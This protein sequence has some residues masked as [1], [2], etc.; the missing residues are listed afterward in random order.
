MKKTF[1]LVAFVL[2]ICESINAQNSIDFS[3]IKSPI[4]FR[5]DNMF[6]FRDPAVVFDNNTFYLYFTLCENSS[7]GGYYNVTAYSK[8]TDLV[9]WTYPKAITPKD[10][11]LN[12][13]SP[14]NIIRYNDEW[15]I[16]LQT[17]PTPN[18]ESFGTKDSRVYIMRSKNLEDWGEPEL[19]KVKGNDVPE[20][21]MGRM[22]DPYLIKDE[23]TN[24]WWCFYKQNGVSMSY[25]PDLE[26]WTYVG[27]HE[28]GENVTILKQGDE[29]VMFHS[30]ANG[31]G[32]K[33]S[34]SL[35]NWGKDVQLLILGQSEWEWSNGRLTAGTVIDLTNKPGINKYIMFFHGDKPANQVMNRAHKE[36]CLAIA[37]S[38]DLIHWEWPSMNEKK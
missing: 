32:V 5:G 36:A 30:P 7:D 17:Y 16:C 31:I 13:S 8:S 12:F 3:K 38:D 15:I 28:A 4:I 1:V 20:S 21:E 25:S 22:I 11:N 19:L 26:S 10:R 27:Y 2:L 23:K 6:A 37:W 9:F 34:K 29:Y 35:D 24:L 18:R 14:G 33:R